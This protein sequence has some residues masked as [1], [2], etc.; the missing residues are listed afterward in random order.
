MLLLSGVLRMSGIPDVHR[1]FPKYRIPLDKVGIQGV[2]AKI[3]ICNNECRE[4]D[5]S[6]N[7]YVDLLSNMRGIHLSRL[8]SCL[9]DCL[10]NCKPNS[11]K[12]FL[13]LLAKKIMDVYV[14][15]RR[16]EIDLE[17]KDYIDYMEPFEIKYV[18]H[19]ERGNPVKWDELTIKLIGL[20]ACPCAQRVYS[21]FENTLLQNTPTHMQRTILEV[22]IKSKE[23]NIDPLKLANSLY[24]S[25]SSPIKTVLKR[26]DEYKL[27]KNALSKPL[28]AEDVVRES[29]AIIYK[30]SNLLDNDSMIIVKVYSMDSIH[31]FNVYSEARYTLNDLR[32]FFE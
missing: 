9:K 15:I 7:I 29:L 5:V 13:E 19:R 12:N 17:T 3:T 16:V 11:L 23:I 28:F 14:E 8:T 31:P 26:I 20:T 24:E 6:L 10:E 30:H 1:E 22:K 2:E 4:Y 27:I 18:I 32:K 21:Y 25:F